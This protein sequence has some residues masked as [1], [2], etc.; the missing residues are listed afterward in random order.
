MAKLSISVDV[1][2]LDLVQ[3]L[4][5]IFTVLDGYEIENIRRVALGLREDGAKDDRWVVG[6]MLD[7]ILD[8]V[9]VESLTEAPDDQA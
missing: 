7:R 5:G 4:T 9:E 1:K 2:N 3:R 6:E 8:F